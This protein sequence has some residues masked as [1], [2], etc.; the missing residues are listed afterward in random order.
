[1]NKLTKA[2]KKISLSK[3][4][5][6]WYDTSEELKQM[7]VK[8]GLCEGWTKAWGNPTRKELISKYTSGIKFAIEHNIPYLPYLRKVFK[9]NCEDMGV[10]IDDETINIANYPVVVCNGNCLG[11]I[12]VNKRDISFYQIHVRHDS[13]LDI[14]SDNDGWVFV[15]MYGDKCKVRCTAKK[16]SNIVIFKYSEDGTEFFGKQAVIKN[17]VNA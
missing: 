15:Y 10:F 8:A 6:E 9:G 13:Y 1:M 17:T 3:E 16:M 2:I 5:R 7:F 11:D 14:V 4:Q 12:L